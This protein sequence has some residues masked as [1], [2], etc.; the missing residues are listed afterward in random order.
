[1]KKFRLNFGLLVLRIGI[2]GLMLFHGISK[3]SNGIDGLVAMFDRQGLPGIIAYLVYLGEVVAPV[4]VLIGYRTKLAS[5]AIAITMV[6]AMIIAHADEILKL[7]DHGEWA[8]E[9]LGLYLLGAIALFFL[10][11]GKFAVSS[12]NKWD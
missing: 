9:V 11:A 12:S 4:L 2:G 3:L 7:G 5:V 6:V 10:G 1:M 8:L